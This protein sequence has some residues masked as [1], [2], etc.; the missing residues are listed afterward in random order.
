MTTQAPARTRYSISVL[1][2]HAVDSVPALVAFES[3]RY[4]F[5]TPGAPSRIALQN[6]VD[7]RKAGHVFLGDFE[8]SAGLPGFILSSVEAGN[9]RTQLARAAGVKSA[10]AFAKLVVN[11]ERVWVRA[12]EPAK[13]QPT[14]AT[15]NGE[16]PKRRRRRSGTRPRGRSRKR[17]PEMQESTAKAKDA[18]SSRKSA[19][20]RDKTARL[21][22]GNERATKSQAD[23]AMFALQAKVSSHSPT[24]FVDPTASHGSRRVQG[25][26]A[27]TADNPVKMSRLPSATAK[28]AT[29]PNVLYLEDFTSAD[30]QNDSDSWRQ[31]PTTMRKYGLFLGREDRPE[32]VPWQV[33]LPD[34][35]RLPTL[36][37]LLSRERKLPPV[38]H[39]SLPCTLEVCGRLVDL[40]TVGVFV[41]STAGG[42][43]STAS[44]T[45][46]AFN[47]KDAAVIRVLESYGTQKHRKSVGYVVDRYEWQGYEGSYRGKSAK[48][49]LPEFANFL[50]QVFKI[51]CY[52]GEIENYG[53]VVPFTELLLAFDVESRIR[54][55]GSQSA[56]WDAFS[57][58]VYGDS[59]KFPNTIS[60]YLAL[61][62][63]LTD[64][65][66]NLKGFSKKAVETA[67]G[68]WVKLT[69]KREA[70]L[71][72]LFEGVVG[73]SAS[74]LIKVGDRELVRSGK[75]SEHASR[76]KNSSGSYAYNEAEEQFMRDLV[77]RVGVMLRRDITKDMR[78]VVCHADETCG[79]NI[80]LAFFACLTLYHIGRGNYKFRQVIACP[81]VEDFSSKVVKG[82]QAGA[83]GFLPMIDEVVKI[84]VPAIQNG[85]SID[86][87]E[88]KELWS[89]GMAT[90][91][92]EWEP[93]VLVLTAARA[94]EA[95][96]AA[97]KY[98]GYGI[99]RMVDGY[100][101]FFA[102]DK[103]AEAAGQRTKGSNWSTAEVKDIFRI[104]QKI[105]QNRVDDLKKR[106][107]AGDIAVLLSDEALEARSKAPVSARQ[108]CAYRLQ[109]IKAADER[110]MQTGEAATVKFP[111]RTPAA[112]QGQK[113][114]TTWRFAKALQ[115]YPEKE[116]VGLISSFFVPPLSERVKRLLANKS[117]E[118]KISDKEEDEEAWQARYKAI[119]KEDEEKAAKVKADKDAKKAAKKTA[120]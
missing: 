45:P 109:E 82:K 44:N 73:S 33:P 52:L 119:K 118:R 67:Y 88:A 40:P 31:T 22:P 13:P 78:E 50:G 103:N 105:Q 38:P 86:E 48:D 106:A 100:D 28:K 56:A 87:K 4:L 81:I 58:L 24:L 69:Q 59:H 96:K 49:H 70:E 65:R 57:C 62:P 116:R 99:V 18:R 120:G 117:L 64:E 20:P 68:S 94:D 83:S 97:G 89:S 19:C 1:T 23:P 93:M 27:A 10:K 39:P 2:T 61:M 46:F 95:L 110:A 26:A 113:T 11:D 76:I 98:Q 30:P 5:N 71:K 21:P 60:E 37:P 6:K 8:E 7:L 75:S 102:I 17:G 85:M 16:D 51:H 108:I 112:L 114:L 66:F 80:V 111:Y 29:E 74:S 34:R 9:D 104:I 79:G 55:S 42:A 25:P 77:T 14:E 3:Q 41:E 47:E 35:G 63:D 15:V 92:N 72:S 32:R 53:P 36:P 115:A 12:P 43:T 91:S 101:R 84:A 107:A 54:L 90:D